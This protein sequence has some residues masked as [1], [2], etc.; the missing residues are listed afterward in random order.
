MTVTDAVD[1]DLRLRDL[2]KTDEGGDLLLVLSSGSDLGINN[3]AGTPILPT[4]SGPPPSFNA[5]MWTG[6]NLQPNLVAPYVL[7]GTLTL[8]FVDSHSNKIVWSGTVSQKF[9]PNN[10]KDSIKRINEAV[11]KLLKDFPPKK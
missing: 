6:S 5:N 4:Y 1:Y 9:S 8:T 7:K 11:D 10:K 2:K 3:P